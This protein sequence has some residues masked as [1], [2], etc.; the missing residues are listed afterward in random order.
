MRILFLSHVFSPAIGGIEASSEF[1]A[2]AFANA[3]YDVR[4]MT[5]TAGENLALPYSII[6]QPSITEMLKQHAWA[7]IIYEN[8]PCLR[9]GWPKLLWNKPSIITLHTWIGRIDGTIALV[10]KLKF[11][12]LAQAKK[13]ITVS[14][15]LQQRCWPA[16]TIIGNSYDEQLFRRR[17]VVRNNDFVFLGRLV[18]DKGV[19]LAIKAFNEVVFSKPLAGLEEATLTIIGAGP[20]REQLEHLAASLPD[21]SRVRF[22]GILKGEDLV[23]E[24]NRHAFQFI[25]ST[26][27]EPFGI[28]AL[29]GIACGLIPIASN[30]GGLPDAVGMAGVTFERG[31]LASLVEVT[32]ELLQNTEQQVRCLAAAPNHLASFSSKTI[33]K[34]FV[35]ILEATGENR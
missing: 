25:P 29:E 34:K 20:D 23:A 17:P 2:G 5:M 33:I 26:W 30:G 27:E 4:L 1:L 19:E 35:N 16:A 7:D 8:N 9:L 11:C 18:S 13:V 24:L 31:Q 32:T 21:P 15:A 10:D 28:V 14:K 22:L 3:G 6:R 12:W